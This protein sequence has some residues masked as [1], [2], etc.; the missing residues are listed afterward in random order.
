MLSKQE[1]R[2]LLLLQCDLARVKLRC[3]QQQAAQAKSGVV[4]QLADAA[5]EAVRHA[6]GLKLAM[7]PAKWK[8]RAAV[9]LGLMALEW[10]ERRATGKRGR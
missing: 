2:E 3:T 9:L 6:D 4:W 10:A 5:G 8:H 1:Q 7:L